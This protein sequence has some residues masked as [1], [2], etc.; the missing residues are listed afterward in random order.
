MIQICEY[1]RCDQAVNNNLKKRRRK[2]QQNEYPWHTTP[3]FAKLRRQKQKGKHNN[4]DNGN[5]CQ[6]RK[7][8]SIINTMNPNDN[9]H[10]NSN[11]QIN[12]N[13]RCGPLYLHYAS[14][15]P[16][17]NKLPPLPPVI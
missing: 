4:Q 8:K 12:S 15:P 5:R 2:R 13:A 3:R 6:Q 14:I 1:Q 9:Y 7:S 11:H 17:P 10:N 16:P